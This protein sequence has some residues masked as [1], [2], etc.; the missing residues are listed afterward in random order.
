M[1]ET[2]LRVHHPGPGLTPA[3]TERARMWCAPLT[4]PHRGL[5]PFPFPLAP[6]FLVSLPLVLLVL[7]L[8]PAVTSRPSTISNR[9][10]HRLSLRSRLQGFQCQPATFSKTIPRL[11]ITSRPQ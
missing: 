2:I 6:Y 8:R 11:S 3:K 10:V 1:G 7:N 9:T 5:S 4:T